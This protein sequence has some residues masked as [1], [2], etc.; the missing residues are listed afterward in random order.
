MNHT[1]FHTYTIPPIQIQ[2]I[3]VNG[4]TDKK[5]IKADLDFIASNWNTT[6]GFDLWEEVP[7]SHFYTRLVVKV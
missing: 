4:V 1:S 3:L 5:V 6:S 2:V 7:G